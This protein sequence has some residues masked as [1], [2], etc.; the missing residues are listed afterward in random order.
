MNLFR[1]FLIFGIFITL[2]LK[3]YSQIKVEDWR[4]HFSY[5]NAK[6]IA[7]ADLR[8]YVATELALFVFE[9]EDGS[10]TKLSKVNGLSDAEIQTIAYNKQNET[11]IIVYKNSNIDILK[12]NVI[13]NLSEIK[14][15]QISFNKSINKISFINNTA[16]LSC[17]FGI[18]LLNTDKLE[19]SDSYII[20]E[21]ASY[22]NINDV[23][24]DGIYL[25]AATDIGLF[26]AELN[27]NLSDY[28]NWNLNPEIPNPD[29][30]YNLLCAFNG[31]LFANQ[32]NPSDQNDTLYVLKNN[33]WKITEQ[34]TNDLKSITATETYIAFA[35]KS[36]LKI[37]DKNMNFQKEINW[38]SFSQDDL[39]TYTAISYAIYDDNQHYFIADNRFGLVH[40]NFSYIQ[41][42]YPNGPYD[43]NTA[44]SSYHKG[45]IITTNGN[46]KSTAWLDPVYNIFENETWKTISISPDTAR[47]F[48]ASAINP[49]AQNQFFIGSWGYGIFEFENEQFK[50]NYNHL[51]SSLQTIDGYDYGY[52]RISDLCF[53]YDNNLWVSN[54]QVAA[55]VSVKTPDGTWKSFNFNGLISNLSPDK[56][57]VT[58]NNHKW[59]IL[60]ES[61]GILVF[62]DNHTPTDTSDDTYK[63]I[64]PT[65]D[66]GEVFPNV[67]AIEEDRDGQIWI[68]TDSGVFTYYNPDNVFSND[69]FADRVQLTSYGNDTTEQYLI[70]TDIVTCIK[71][72]GADR[73]WIGTRSSGV[74]LISDNGK[75]EI[76]NF[77]RYNSPLI[78]D[79]IND[80][81][82][83]QETGEVFFLTDKGIVSFRSDAT[84]G[85]AEF[86]AVYVFPN[87]VRPDYS[88]KITISGLVTDVNVKI[89][90]ISGQLVFETTALGGQAIWDGKTFNGRKVNTGVYLVFCT[91]TDGSQTFV[92][93]FIFL[94]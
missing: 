37:Y 93:K 64:K 38:Y 83:N 40:D 23:N 45:K 65:A 76:R 90:D 32:I 56:I 71:T 70:N 48:W 75:E 17:G 9:K 60:T 35:S 30:K 58:K 21:N 29:F 92:T 13:Y 82:I 67:T 59:I 69:F 87:P 88:G 94:H 62:D 34:E 26:R 73:K 89:T 2:F 46:N 42:T 74:F 50:S 6:V 79:N 14:R 63:I 5:K 41:Y 4:D 25:Y 33:E 57:I 19:F 36:N 61:K 54:Q 55:P 84:E 66:N 20:G 24:T 85:A 80:I 31:M 72:D 18:V 44:H 7:D 68:G 86:S 15:K 8:V 91:N 49:L 22:L 1:F 3:N 28:R 51:N 11:L 77:N 16:Y 27:N 39:S 47:N 10:V 81:T 43:N 53:D 12:D 78:S 52:I